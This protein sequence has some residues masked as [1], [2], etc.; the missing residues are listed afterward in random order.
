MSQNPFL[1]ALLGVLYIACVSSLLFYGSHYIQPAKESVFIPI[2]MLSLF[3]LSA[4]IM[5]YLFLFEPVSLFLSGEKERGIKL[6][7]QTIGIF[8]CITLGA[9]ILAFLVFAGA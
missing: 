9:F 7:L 8:A 1:N 6:F 5:G 4:S 2:A 3:V